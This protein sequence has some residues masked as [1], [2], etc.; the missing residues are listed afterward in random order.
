MGLLTFLAVQ[1]SEGGRPS[2]ETFLEANAIFEKACLIQ[3]ADGHLWRERMM[4]GVREVLFRLSRGEDTQT[5]CHRLLAQ[6][7]EAQSELQVPAY[8]EPQRIVLLWLLGES[9]WRRGEDPLPI[10]AKTMNLPAYHS[11]DEAESLNTLARYRGQHGLDPRPQIQRAE[12]LVTPLKGVDGY[13][14][15][16]T[17]HGESLLI[18][19]NWEWWTGR[20]PLGT[21]RRGIDQLN[22]AVAKKPDCVYPYF[23]LPLLHALE[24]QVRMG[25]GQ[26]AGSAIE[27][28]LQ[29]GRRA[30]AIRPD[31]F[32][33]QLGLCE[34]Y[35]MQAVERA[36]KDEDTAPSLATAAQVLREARRL[37]PTDWRIALAE[38]RLGLLEATSAKGQVAAGLSRAEAATQRGL[39]VK[40]D[41]PEL[42]W[43]RG[44]AARLRWTLLGDSE[45][46]DRA[47]EWARKALALCPDLAPARELLQKVR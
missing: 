25:R 26:P 46:K 31:H 14:Y 42:L 17:L 32:R 5:L 4:S 22:Q 3:P 7:K 2:L 20:D 21:L 9:R 36:S 45:A 19:A 35:L 27:Q 29:G 41:A 6:L 43:A 23:H 12:L 33:S 37:N 8:L 13:F 44:E 1:A 40:A 38:A 47:R 15:N 18:Q 34:A 28:A 39:A 10:L 11:A 30:V 16:N 24:A